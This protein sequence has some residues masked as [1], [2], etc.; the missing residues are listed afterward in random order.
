MTLS[1]IQR[2][3]FA[4]I[5]LAGYAAG[6]GQAVQV[7]RTER[8][9]SSL[10]AAGEKMDLYTL[11][12][13]DHRSQDQVASNSEATVSKFDL[14]APG[15]ARNEYIQALRFLA[16]NDLNRGVESL[17]KAISIYPNY[18]AAHIAGSAYFRLKEFAL[19]REEFTRALHLTITCPVRF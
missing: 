16:K 17:K 19:A 18:V 8:N 3:A 6:Q 2:G 13:L 5:L 14:K 4:I 11:G 7:E 12:K 1:F 10:F 9:L 15:R